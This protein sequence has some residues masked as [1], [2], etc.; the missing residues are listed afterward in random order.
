MNLS[1]RETAHSYKVD[2]STREV[3]IGMIR[4]G[5]ERSIGGKKQELGGVWSLKICRDR[6]F[7]SLQ[8]EDLVEVSLVVGCF[9]F[10]IFRLN[11]NICL[12]VFIIH[13]T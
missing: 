13:V 5:R 6:I 3:E 1:K 9:A 2:P 7:P 12:W 10:L 8:S 11:P 4:L